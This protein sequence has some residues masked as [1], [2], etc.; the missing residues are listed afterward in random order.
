MHTLCSWRTGVKFRTTQHN[1]LLLV[2]P[3]GMAELNLSGPEFGEPVDMVG[4][5]GAGCQLRSSYRMKGSGSGRRVYLRCVRLVPDTLPGARKESTMQALAVSQLSIS[6]VLYH[7]MR[8]RHGVCLSGAAENLLWDGRYA[9][10]M[11]ECGALCCAAITSLRPP[12]YQD[13]GE[14]TS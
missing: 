14:D 1:K 9:S 4:R 10:F 5:A 11:A 2:F 8:I 3:R 13:Q 6:L 12:S 7:V